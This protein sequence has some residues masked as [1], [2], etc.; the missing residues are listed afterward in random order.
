M[1]LCIFDL[2]KRRFEESHPWLT[3]QYQSS[4]FDRSSMRLG[5]AFSKCR[6]LANTAIPPRFALH[7]ANIYLVKGVNATT[8]I[9]GNTLSEVEVQEI[10]ERR[11]QLPPSQAYLQHEVENVRDVIVEI[12]ANS[13]ADDPFVLTPDWLKEANTKILNG[14]ECEPHVVPGEF[15]KE[16][17]LVGSVYRG[18]PPE[19]V[20]YLIDRFCDWINSMLAVSRDSSHG[21]DIRFAQ[22][23]Y[24]A[25]L[26]HL[27]LAWIHPFGDGN[28]RTARALECAILGRSQFVPWVSSNLLSNHYNRTRNRYYAKLA[29]ASR[30]RDVDGFIAYAADGFVDM[31]RE[32]ISDTHQIQR[33]L[34]WVN[35]V[36]EQFNQ[37]TQGETSKR[38][39]ALLLGL[40]EGEWTPR[41]KVK[42]LTPDLA[43]MYAALSDKAVSH[44]INRLR[45]LDLLEVSRSRG[46][47]PRV[48]LMDA[49]LP[50]NTTPILPSN[51]AQ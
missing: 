45:H 18:A 46:I 31:L 1:K 7:L 10:L 32:Q 39:R 27:Y 8:A 13:A 21:D 38:R 26:S 34:A 33:W 51:G 24:A 40:P 49:F 30:D 11:K 15:T 9:E 20:P 47:R 37:E 48:E 50:E 6:H 29:A 36:H 23:F 5:E 44:D 12:H 3:F 41:N 14:I 17:L 42:K 4:G 35:Y 16:P 2:V 22:T 28:G 19:D 43:A 25:V